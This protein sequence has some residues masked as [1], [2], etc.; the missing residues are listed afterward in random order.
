M[1]LG[2]KGKMRAKNYRVCDRC[3]SV[4]IRDTFKPYHRYSIIDCV[5]S[6]FKYPNSKKM[7]TKQKTNSRCFDLCEKCEKEYKQF[8][9][10]T[11]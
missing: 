5:S 2:R 1:W 3:K 4:F 7:G 11:K 6:R 8:M 9:E 10:R